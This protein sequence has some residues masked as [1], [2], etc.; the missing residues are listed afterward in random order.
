MLKKRKKEEKLTQIALFSSYAL[1]LSQ[2]T[3]ILGF[4]LIMFLIV[5][6]FF[7]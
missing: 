5:A 3:M 2:I 7:L 6:G 4:F 1:I